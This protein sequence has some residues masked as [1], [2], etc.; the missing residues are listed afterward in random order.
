M[1]VLLIEDEKLTRIS[2]GNILR[3]QGDEVE[4]CETGIQG[5]E[6]IDKQTWDLVITDLRLPKTNGMDILKK[7]KEIQPKCA[8]IV[9]T[10]F[11]TIETAV[12][13]LKL[14]AYDYLTKPFEPD[15]LLQIVNHIRQFREVSM[16]NK[17]LKKKI[18]KMSANKVIGNSVIMT[19]LLQTAKAVA[20]NDYTILIQGES[21]TGKEVIAKYIH[22]NSNRKKNPFVPINCAVI[23]ETLL[24]SELFGHEKGS[25][26]GA[27]KQHIGYF[28]RANGGTIFID[29][30]DDFP[31]PLQVKLLRVLQ[32]RELVRIGGHETIKVDVRVICATKV[33]LMDKVKKNEFRDDLY[34]RL[35]IIPLN[36]PPLKDR[37]EDIPGLIRHFLEKRGLPHDTLVL[38]ADQLMKLQQ[39]NW[40]GNV[41]ELE[42]IVE[43]LLAL[44]QVGALDE[45]VFD[46]LKNTTELEKSPAKDYPP[47]VEYLAACEEE[48]IHW[49]LD[50]SNGNISKAAEKLE[51]PRSTLRSKME[52]L[53][54]E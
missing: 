28:E 50:H 5:L 16:E 15:K 49:A 42:N 11:A 4:L 12:E 3:K 36:L 34:Y 22:E 13:S 21:G 17:K 43:R 33:D 53:G 37:K 35:N 25:F 26:S 14:G 7:V 38:N 23:P 40:P 45:R 9:I 41:R 48:I 31:Y 30:I 8:V 2:L 44:S 46:T 39:Y 6:Q 52:K 1:R 10:A 54:I 47:L 20:T 32:E 18:Q 24:E 29:D 19:K 51:I 27:I